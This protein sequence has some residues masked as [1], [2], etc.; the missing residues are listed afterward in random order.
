MVR[1]RVITPSRGVAF[2]LKL[3]GCFPIRVPGP[4]YLGVCSK[5]VEQFCYHCV[6]RTWEMVVDAV[7]RV[8]SVF[9]PPRGGSINT[10]RARA[11]THT[12]TH[13]HTHTPHLPSPCARVNY[14]GPF[15]PL[16]SGNGFFPYKI[17][18][19]GWCLGETP[20]GL[21]T[22]HCMSWK[23]DRRMLSSFLTASARSVSLSKLD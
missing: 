18:P 17:H 16:Q 22:V 11:H 12:C 20:S 1:S 5:P 19:I 2:W 14:C 7:H 6:F 13:M 8:H 4:V 10:A 3:W 23:M 9:P 21:G 15:F